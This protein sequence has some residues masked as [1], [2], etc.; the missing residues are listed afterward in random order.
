MRF[1]RSSGVLLHPT[2]LPSPHGIGDL[3]QAAY[4]FLDFLSDTNQYI[5]QLLPLGPTGYGDSP[6]QSFSAFAGNPMLISLELLAEERLLEAADIEP[7]DDFDEKRVNYGP[8]I[9]YKTERLRRAF[10]NFEATG[11]HD[12]DYDVFVSR[13]QD[14][15]E[16]YALFMA[17]KTENG[18]G[19]WTGWDI[20]LIQR[21]PQALTDA[22]ER[23]YGE[24]RYHKFLQWQFFKQWDAL[25]QAATDRGIQIVGDI[26]IFVAHDSA[27]V[28]QSPHLFYL[29]PDGQ[30]TFVAGVPPDYFSATGQ[31]W[32][33]PLYKWD[34]MEQN[35]FEW[36][37]RRIKATLRLVDII[38][39]DHFRGFEA[40]WEIPGEEETAVKGR[41][42]KAPGEALFKRISD[43]LGQL[44][45]IA[46]N[47]GV[48]TPEVEALREQFELP[49][50][51]VLQFAFG[52]GPDND[53]LPHSYDA[54]NVVYTGT[55][56]NETTV[57][58]FTRTDTTGTTMTEDELAGERTFVRQYAK[59]LEDS[60]IHWDLIRLAFA[61]VAVIAL[62]PL[63]DLIG[64]GNEARMNYPS[65]DSGNWQWRYTPDQL[66]DNIRHRLAELTY[67]Y[68]RIVDSDMDDENNRAG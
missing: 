25:H 64:L 20:K 30:P 22:H 15:L 39:I 19:S 56:D 42:V 47:L 52:N 12:T 3:G 51:K 57:G 2:S 37:L 10:N 61:S 32:G 14:W 8:V 16:D 62:V 54:N 45:L 59:V 1:P 44:P 7:I 34:L 17:L 11:P 66:T 46:E 5:W 50:M 48:I 4:D 31:R 49:G 9:S 67:V 38:R 53:F 35:G 26:P 6:Y 29:E 18:G 68:D 41:W 21:D 24:I 13:N 55:H 65:S 33:N 40:Y 28:W 58:W 43:E 23:L 63:Q 60:E 27:D 36:W